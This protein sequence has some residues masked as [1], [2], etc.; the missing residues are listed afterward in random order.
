LDRGST[1]DASID[2]FP[3]FGY[4]PVATADSPQDWRG[5][6]SRRD[7]D[8]PFVL[9][10]SSS[11]AAGT[12]NIYVFQPKSVGKILDLPDATQFEIEGDF[13]KPGLLLSIGVNRWTIR[14]DRLMIESDSPN[15]NCGLYMS[16]VLEWL[17]VT[18][19]EALGH[20][21]RFVGELGDFP[22]A[23]QMS[24]LLPLS[25][26]DEFETKNRVWHVGLE[27]ESVTFNLQIGIKGPEVQLAAN[28]HFQPPAD[29]QE[30]RVRFA[31]GF[32]EFRETATRLLE[33]SFAVSI[34]R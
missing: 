16:R 18:P 10:K 15:E 12:F 33:S 19:I 1:R 21:F 11:V 5:L 20:N 26:V 4:S 14:P 28:V 8:V 29:A 2:S 27:R 34:K 30:N 9:T 32:F 24:N 3:A 22:S 13:A 31:K 7:Y 23:E 17:P 25:H 6:D